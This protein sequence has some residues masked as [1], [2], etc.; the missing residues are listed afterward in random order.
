[1]TRREREFEDVMRTDRTTSATA[2]QTDEQIPCLIS[3]DRLA[4]RVEE[5]AEQVSADYAGKPLLVIGVLHGAFVFMADLFRRLTTPARCGFVM[6]SS[7]GDEM[8]TSGE[9]KLKLDVTHSVEGMHVLLVDDI[10]DT[11]ISVDWLI[12][13]IRAKGPIDL[14][15]CA[16]LDKPA[17]RRIEVQ[18]DYLGFDIPDRFV[19][20]YGVDCAG[21]YRDLPYIGYVPANE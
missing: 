6:I 11:G 7:Y 16:L 18:I 12:K 20:G 13:H 10:V 17:R 3:A 9:V 4:V 15:L 14:R 8:V 5:L 19:V 21:R 2:E 1:V